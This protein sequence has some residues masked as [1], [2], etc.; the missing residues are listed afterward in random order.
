VAKYHGFVGVQRLDQLARSLGHP[1][2]AA[3]KKRYN[4]A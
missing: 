3:A 1:G 2:P 4:G